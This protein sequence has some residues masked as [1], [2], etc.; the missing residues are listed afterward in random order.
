M[1]QI[2]P[3]G[4]GCVLSPKE[5]YTGPADVPSLACLAQVV[6]NVI[7]VAF[8]FLGAVCL[9]FLLYGA[10][11]F[12]LSRGDQKALQKAQGTMTYAVIGTVF[13]ALSFMAVNFVA[14]SLGISNF[15]SNFSFY[16]P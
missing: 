6:V 4:A 7:N 3:D 16:Q 5:G 13:V 9:I 2:K 15:L 10:L 8:M 11:L 12:V 1:Q 14:S